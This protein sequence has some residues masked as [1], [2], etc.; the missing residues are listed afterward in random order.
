MNHLSPQ[1]A[2]GNSM[3][4]PTGAAVRPGGIQ[5]LTIE[6]G[7]N[8]QQHPSHMVPTGATSP[9]NAANNPQLRYKTDNAMGFNQGAVVGVHHPASTK[10][11][12]SRQFNLKRSIAPPG[13][14][15][16]NQGGTQ[17]AAQS[18]YQFEMMQPMMVNPDNDVRSLDRIMDQNQGDSLLPKRQPQYA[19]VN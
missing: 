4:T 5:S 16:G 6:T 12:N 3:V 8:H 9:V 7:N 19:V 2:T 18:N 13:S 14:K 17:G 1:N 15:G 10:N 11:Q